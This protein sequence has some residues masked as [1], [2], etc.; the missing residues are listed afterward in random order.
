M[1][2][3]QPK[4][5]F[6][7][8]ELKRRDLITA[9]GAALA[10]GAL[11]GTAGAHN[12]DAHDNGAHDWRALV[13]GA[14]DS[15]G[16]WAL[17]ELDYDYDALEPHIDAETMEIHHTR[18]HQGYVTGLIGNEEK[19]AEARSSGDFALVE[20]WS[21]KLSFNGGGHFLH[22]IFWDCM[23]PDGGGD[24][25]GAFAEAVARDFGSIPA[26]RAQFAAASKAV[27]GSGW[28]ILAWQA[29]S[30]RLTILQGQNQNLRS[31]WGIVPLLAIDVWEHAYYLKYQNRRAAYVD[32]WWSTVDWRKVEK[33]YALV[34]G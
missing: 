25:Q 4:G 3:T 11:F 20:H 8:T 23:G 1:T 19:L 18:H 27:E 30:G 29:A 31:Q 33:R 17:P 5:D 2:T 21:N 28:G 15:E 32:A 26:M 16:K 7:M 9:G 10:A 13:P 22:C 12:H 6:A 14:V 34:A 24:P